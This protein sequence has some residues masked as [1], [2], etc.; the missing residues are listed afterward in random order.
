MLEYTSHHYYFNRY[1]G[2]EIKGH[3]M[4]GQGDKSAHMKNFMG[5]FMTSTLAPLQG[6][7]EDYWC[8]LPP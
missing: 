3:F 2:E 8:F 7:R 1:S 6:F 4:H 5:W